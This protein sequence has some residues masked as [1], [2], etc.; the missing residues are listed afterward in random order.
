[1]FFT[2]Q[3]GSVARVGVVTSLGSVAIGLLLAVF[4]VQGWTMPK[5]LALLLIALLIAMIAASVAVVVYEVVRAIRLFFEHRATSPSWVS[6]ERPGLLD[7][8]A[9]GIR[10]SERFA[11]ELN[12][13]NG[14][15]TRLG[16]KLRRHTEAFAGGEG[17]DAKRRQKR[18]DRSA[19]DINRSAVFIEKR[20]AFL[21]A[22][23]KDITRN[24]EG[25][26]AV[27]DFG[28]P[29]DLAQGQEFRAVLDGGCRVT[30]DT[31]AIIAEYREATRTT[32]QLNL[33]RTMRIASGRLVS[34][35]DGIVKTMRSH[36][37]GTRKLVQ[38]LD[39][40]IAEAEARLRSARP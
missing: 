31:L 14:D 8:E 11:K 23:V 5:I 22:L 16:K 17:T 9:D 24:A 3:P 27:A 39:R 28:T 1:M 26:I 37:S 12:K 20:L 4:Q 29:E 40:K 18:A 15:T 30:S 21:Q 19:K 38:V 2:W 35:L 36:E 32:Q 33:S 10:A 13:L 34:A 7:Y 25:L 6:S